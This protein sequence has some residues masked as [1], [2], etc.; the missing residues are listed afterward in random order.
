Y[1]VRIACTVGGTTMEAVGAPRLP[2]INSL[3][4]CPVGVTANSGGMNWLLVPNLWDP[5]RDTWDLTETNAGNNGNK[6][7]STPGYLR[8]SVRITI[9]GTG[10]SNS[11]TVGFGS[12]T[13]V[14][15]SG[16]VDPVSAFST[17][18][19]NSSSQPL[20]TGSLTSAGG[21]DGFL[22]AMRMGVQD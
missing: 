7:L 16:R 2:Y 8:P 3:A 22:Q 10:A 17:V 4:A 1:P 20:A 13:T 9:K 5:F 21:R 11:A 14:A 15:N 12:T 18:T 19:V 6:P